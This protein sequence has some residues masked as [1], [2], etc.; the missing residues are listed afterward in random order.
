MKHSATIIEDTYAYTSRLF[1]S[2]TAELAMAHHE[3]QKAASLTELG[4]DRRLE[5]VLKDVE[6]TELLHTTND[7]AGQRTA[8]AIRTAGAGREKRW[9]CETWLYIGRP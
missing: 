3:D 9:S 8:Q 7:L 5:F 1:V 6:F 2:R 4:R